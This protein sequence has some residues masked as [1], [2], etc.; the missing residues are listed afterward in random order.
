MK[1]NYLPTHLVDVFV[2]RGEE[3]WDYDRISCYIENIHN[4][5]FVQQPGSLS[6]IPGL[7][8]GD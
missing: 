3:T 8:V 4:G 1:M 5:D 2:Q 7:C 6:G